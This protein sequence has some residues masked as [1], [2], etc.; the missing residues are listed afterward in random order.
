MRK[1]S[2]LV[3]L[4]LAPLSVQAA[5]RPIG[6]TYV[7]TNI[8]D[9]DCTVD[10]AWV[11]LRDWALAWSNHNTDAY[12]SFYKPKVSPDPEL[13]FDDWRMRRYVRVSKQREIGIVIYALNI[14]VVP[15]ERVRITFIQRYTSPTYSDDV[16]KEIDF[17]FIENDLQMIREVVIKEITPEEFDQ[18]IKEK[19]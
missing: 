18:I 6:S 14:E 15:N 8:H 3:L 17:E 12:F 11:K 2:L 13:S 4:I 16:V 7:C 10:T 9:Y 5:D 19:R 1:I